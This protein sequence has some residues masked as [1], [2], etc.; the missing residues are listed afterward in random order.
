[1]SPRPRCLCEK[2]IF[3][4]LSLPC[5][6]LKVVHFFILSSFFQHDFPFKISESQRLFFLDLFL[7]DVLILDADVSVC[8]VFSVVLKLSR[9]EKFRGPIVYPERPKS[10]LCSVNVQKRNVRFGKQNTIFS[11]CTFFLR[12]LV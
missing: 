7:F 12:L 6:W 3:C 2:R 9:L 4:K 10:K 1:M 11:V 8:D 5:G